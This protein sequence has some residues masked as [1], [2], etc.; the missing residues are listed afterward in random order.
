MKPPRLAGNIEF[1]FNQPL[2]NIPWL[3][4]EELTLFSEGIEIE[5]FGAGN[6]EYEPEAWSYNHCPNLD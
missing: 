3:S 4:F 1:T 2:T 6:V 5:I